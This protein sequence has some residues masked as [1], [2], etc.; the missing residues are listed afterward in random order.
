MCGYDIAA[1]FFILID[2][3]LKRNSPAQVHL[4]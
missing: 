4:Q 1:A 3:T 2:Q